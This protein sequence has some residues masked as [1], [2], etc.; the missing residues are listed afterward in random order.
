MSLKAFHLIFIIASI[1]LAFGLA[2]AELM[3]YFSPNGG[4]RWDLVW[5]IVA[6][7]AGLGL[8]GYEIYFLKKLKNVSYV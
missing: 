1:L 8:I 4:G 7:V 3:S 5:G 2:T 6:I